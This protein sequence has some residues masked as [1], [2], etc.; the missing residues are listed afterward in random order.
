MATRL[1]SELLNRIPGPYQVI[2][3]LKDQKIEGLSFDSRSCKTG[4][5]FFAIPGVHVDGNDF[6]SGLLESAPGAIIMSRFPDNGLVQKAMTMHIPL[7]YCSDIRSA[8]AWISKE[9][10]DNPD[11]Q[12]TLIGVT[13]T[14]GKSSTVWYIQQLLTNLGLHSG[15]ISTVAMQTGDQPGPNSLRQSTP[16]APEIFDLLA[17]MVNQGKTHGVIEATSHGLSDRTGR[18]AALSF[19]TAVFTNISHEHLEF[20]GTFDQYLFDK[21]NLFRKLQ[22]KPLPQSRANPTLAVINAQS[23]FAKYLASTVDNHHQ[24]QFYGIK[25]KIP[26]ENQDLPLTLWASQVEDSSHG[27]QSLMHF[28][29]PLG[30]PQSM[31]VT[32]AIPGSFT[33]E[34]LMAAAL[35]VHNQSIGSKKPSLS[36]ILGLLPTLKGVKGRMRIIQGNQPF[37]VIVDYAHTPGSFEKVFP[38]FR[39][40]TPGKLIA[41]FGSGGERDEAKRPIQG[42]IAGAFA[43][44]L[45]LTN[46]DPR[47]EDPGQ[48]L[49]EIA[50]GVDNPQVEVIKIVDRYDA[51]CYAIQKAQPGDTLVLLGKG[52]EQSII[53]GNEKT[54]WDEETKAREALIEAGFQV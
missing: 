48:I 26:K 22:T 5:L 13:G 31:K 21:A 47:L 49:T 2:T 25:E 36:E 23:P 51:I 30:K 45:I 6:V 39:A 18:L 34:N 16:E 32:L 42:K 4:D 8:L 44:L 24:I 27:V 7:I 43:N 20:H 14:D 11:D 10:F 41:L 33:L 12:L 40:I 50:R 17:T 3:K 9:W 37:S 53:I 54:P 29:D 19:Q 15:F 28:F 52:H 1:L 46:E 35:A 38:L